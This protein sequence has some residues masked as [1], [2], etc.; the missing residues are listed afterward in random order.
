MKVVPVLQ[1]SFCAFLG[2]IYLS[3]EWR[4]MDGSLVIGLL[5][6]SSVLIKLTS[7][8]MYHA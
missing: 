7:L 6:V 8:D 3:V 4:G 5:T 2:V 1:E